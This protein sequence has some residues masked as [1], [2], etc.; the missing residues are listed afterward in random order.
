MWY[1]H[2]AEEF[3]KRKKKSKNYFSWN[4]DGTQILTASADMTC[5]LWDVASCNVVTNFTFGN[6]M[7]DYQVSTLWLD[8]DNVFSVNL[9]GHIIHLDLNNPSQPKKIWKVKIFN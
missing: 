2:K 3:C 8:D 7:G 5:K 6:E 4:T 1:I 9:N